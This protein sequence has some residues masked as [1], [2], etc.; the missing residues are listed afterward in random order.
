ME[1]FMIHEDNQYL[2]SARVNGIET[3]V[4]PFDVVIGS[5]RNGQTYLSWSDNQLLQLPVSYYTPARQWCNSPGFPNYFFFGRVVTPNCMECHSTYTKVISHETSE[6][7]KTSVIYGITCQRCHPG[8]TEHAAFQLAHPTEKESKFAVNAAHLSRQLRMDACALCHSGLR[9]ALEPAFSYQVGD[10][11][12]KYST[13]SPVSQQ[14][15]TLDVHG[16]QYGLL[17]ASKCYIKSIDMDCSTCHNVHRNEFQ[18]T[19]IFSTK[20]MSCHTGAGHKE[21]TVK[22]NNNIVLGNDCI[23]CHMPVQAS[24]KIRL[25]VKS[26]EQLLPD[27]L[28]SHFISIN[29]K[30]TEEF[31]IMHNK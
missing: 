14:G 26:G 29:K 6:Y 4:A 2:Q 24:K 27:F 23:S 15:D 10:E 30:A 22:T 3:T 25:N 17:T 21:C 19:R 7:D 13:G 5:G 11:L 8:A 28:H 16:N 12:D 20:C 1:E 18:A 9:T 31:M